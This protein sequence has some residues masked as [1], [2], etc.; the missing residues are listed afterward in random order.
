ML[1]GTDVAILS[2][3]CLLSTLCSLI[4]QIHVIVWWR[5]VQIAQHE[6]KVNDPHNPDLLLANGSVGMD[7]VL[8]YI[9]EPVTSTCMNL[10]LTAR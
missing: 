9:R 5:D 4:Q 7:L 2:Y 3:L 8:Y 1:P 6:F 10:K